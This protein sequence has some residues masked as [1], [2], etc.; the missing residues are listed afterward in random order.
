MHL[1]FSLLGNDYVALPLGVPFGLCLRS[2]QL[3]VIVGDRP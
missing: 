3:L 1:D 2:L